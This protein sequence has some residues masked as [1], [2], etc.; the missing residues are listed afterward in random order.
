MLWANLIE[1]Y[2]FDHA[3]LEIAREIVST[4]DAI[5]RLGNFAHGDPP[6]IEGA[7]GGMVENPALVAARQHRLVLGRL[8]KQLGLSELGEPSA[9][10]VPLRAVSQRRSHRPAADGS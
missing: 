1:D 2:E 9:P 7:H 10:A 8:V 4:V 6:I 3:E 5:E